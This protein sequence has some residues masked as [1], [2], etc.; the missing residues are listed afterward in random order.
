MVGVGFRNR[1]VALP[2]PRVAATK[3]MRG[4]DAAFERAVPFQRF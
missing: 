3:S 1:I 4:K 2:A